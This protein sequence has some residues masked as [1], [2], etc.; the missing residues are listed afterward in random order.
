M[1]R[2]VRRNRALSRPERAV[3]IAV[4]CAAFHA[5]L[6]PGVAPASRRQAARSAVLLAAVDLSAI[7]ADFGRRD[8]LFRRDV[9]TGTVRRDRSEAT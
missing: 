9:I 8:H 6:V 7:T 3:P 4:I 1:S 2:H 5:R